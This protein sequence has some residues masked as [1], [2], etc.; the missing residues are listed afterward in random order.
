[1][2]AATRF[3]FEQD[4]GR[5]GPG[6]MAPSRAQVEREQGLAAARLH[7][8]EAGRVEGERR[9]RAALDARLAAAVFTHQQWKVWHD[10]LVD[11][12]E[13]V[14]QFAEISAAGCAAG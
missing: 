12:P 2:S 4:F 5:P 14:A 11:S 8:Y 1:M 6:V 10:A 13:L 9:A 7:G 3:L